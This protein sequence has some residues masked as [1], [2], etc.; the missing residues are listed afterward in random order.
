M[1]TGVSAVQMPSLH[2]GRRITEWRILCVWWRRRICLCDCDLAQP[3]YTPPL[4]RHRWRRVHIDWWRSVSG[5]IEHKKTEK[6]KVHIWGGLNYYFDLITIHS[7]TVCTFLFFAGLIWTK[8][9]TFQIVM[10]FIWTFLSIEHFWLVGMV[11]VNSWFSPA[12][13]LVE[14]F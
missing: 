2:S 13:V 10:S 12:L 1:S 5:G 8:N 3:P 6:W 9:K 7:S 4:L 11:K 14:S